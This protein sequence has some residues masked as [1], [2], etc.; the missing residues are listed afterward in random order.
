MPYNACEQSY[1]SPYAREYEPLFANEWKPKV[2][3]IIDF[4]LTIIE[5]ILKEME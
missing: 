5:P 4:Y 3:D 2:E 1:G